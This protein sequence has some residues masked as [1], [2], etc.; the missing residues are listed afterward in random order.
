MKLN[1][2][3]ALALSGVM[4][5][6]M[7]AGC[8]TDGKDDSSSEV[9]TPSTDA[10]SVMND[11]QDDVVFAANADL[12]AA[13]S[14]AVAKA[15]YNDVKDAP[16][17]ASIIN[18]NNNNIYKAMKTKVVGL[19][20]TPLADTTSGYGAALTAVESKTTKVALYYVEANG[21][22]EEQALKNVVTIMDAGKFKDTVTSSGSTYEAAY[23]GAVSVQKVTETDSINDKTESAYVIAVSVTQTV[24]K[25]DATANT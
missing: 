23:T 22:S 20:T 7:L 19:T 11:A 10:V 9:T 4:A 2:I 12:D 5:V 16:Y 15:N 21:L 25:A 8:S 6:S 18:T 13:L 24:T 3:L 14:A 17:N 1:K